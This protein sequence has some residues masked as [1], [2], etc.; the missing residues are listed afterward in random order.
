MYLYVILHLNRANKLGS[1][2]KLNDYYNPN[3]LSH[4]K[5]LLVKTMGFTDQLFIFV[6][7]ETQISLNISLYD[8]KLQQC[9]PNNEAREEPHRPYDMY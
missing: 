6:Q 8:V 1:W 4:L 9:V 7:Q 2:Q 5:R 3:S